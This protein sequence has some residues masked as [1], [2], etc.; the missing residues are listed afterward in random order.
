MAES[1][2]GSPDR[3]ATP[4]ELTSDHP[5]TAEISS[6]RTQAQSVPP[7]GG[8][9]A[10]LAPRQLPDELGRLGDYRVLELLGEG[11]MGFVF[12]AEDLALKRMIA[13]KVMRPEVAAKPQAAERFLREGRA[14]ASLK[15][16]HIITVYQVGQAQGVPYLAMEFLEGRSLLEWFRQQTAAVPLPAALRVARDTLRGLALA[17]DKGFIHR[18]IK[19]ANL[20]VEKG[21]SRIKILDFGLTR[22]VDGDEQLTQ[23]GV[24]LGTPAY[25]APEQAAGEVVDPRADLFSVGVVI[26]MLLTGKN[27]FLRNSTMATLGAVTYEVQAPLF[28]IRPDVPR[29]LSDFL[30][31][32]MAKKPA[33]RPA[34]AKAA[35]AEL[36]AI[37]NQL[38]SGQAPS[39]P[40]KAPVRVAVSESPIESADNRAGDSEDAKH[41]LRRKPRKPAAEARGD[42]PG[43]R[44][45]TRLLFVGGIVG[46]LAVVLIGILFALGKDWGTKPTV[47]QPERPPGPGTPIPTAKTPEPDRRAAEL[48]LSL[49]GIVTVNDSPVEVQAAIDLPKEPF[50][51]TDA[52]LSQSR[53]SDQGMEVF[54]DCKNLKSL[55]LAE[56]KITDQGLACLAGCTQLEFL[57]LYKVPVSE[58]GLK[59]LQACSQLSQL[60]LNHTPTNDAGL[61]HLK[62]FTKLTDLALLGTQVTKAK[63]LELKAVL[64]KCRIEWNGGVLEPK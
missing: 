48:V 56:A 58:V 47:V 36:L 18:D 25:M 62:A 35:L 50:H 13:L 6:E 19:P 29:S 40:A 7:L 16:D 11:G 53:M 2:A 31:R 34:H 37:Q 26:Y 5:Q 12:R 30:D 8:A 24:V 46:I 21:T 61:E 55:V 54:R 38:P 43:P 63:V 20:W 39:G 15:S 32:L 1:F 27:P 23:D 44:S 10:F 42:Q 17:H 60:I 49:G 9:F 33:G 59:H 41:D 22:S 64:P 52:F 3:N 45:R 51:L 4:T 57:S 28:T 14:A